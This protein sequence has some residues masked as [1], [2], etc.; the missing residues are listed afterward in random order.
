GAPQQTKRY[1]AISSFSS[2][3]HFEIRKFPPPNFP[4][5]VSALHI[6]AWWPASTEFDLLFNL[7]LLAFEQS[8]YAAVREIPDPPTD[9]KPL[10][11]VCGF[12]PEKHSLNFAAHVHV[13]SNFHVSDAHLCLNNAFRNLCSNTKR[14]RVNPLGL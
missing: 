9:P 8:L 11:K 6:S 14:V 7:L 2:V 10:S 13:R 4:S 12:R 1:H 5:D 3:Q